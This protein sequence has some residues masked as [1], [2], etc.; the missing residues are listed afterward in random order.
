MCE[1]AIK[2][3]IKTNNKSVSSVIL[4]YDVEIY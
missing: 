1:E 3:L 2:N 4:I